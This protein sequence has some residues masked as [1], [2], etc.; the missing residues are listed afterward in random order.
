MSVE[1][2]PIN[3]KNH[4]GYGTI[5]NKLVAAAGSPYTYI[6]LKPDPRY[7]LKENV[8]RLVVY[9][10]K[11]MISELFF[12]TEEGDVWQESHQHN[13]EAQHMLGILCRAPPTFRN[14][15]M[16]N[17]KTVVSDWFQ[18]SKMHKEFLEKISTW[19]KDV[20]YICRFLA[21]ASKFYGSMD[22]MVRYPVCGHLAKFN[23]LKQFQLGFLDKKKNEVRIH[24]MHILDT[25]LSGGHFGYWLVKDEPIPPNLTTDTKIC[26]MEWQ[27]KDPSIKRF[28]GTQQYAF[29]LQECMLAQGFDAWRFKGGKAS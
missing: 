7:T 8:Q 2:R 1:L 3:D 14:Q 24:M 27:D 28:D 11:E 12:K 23:S 18:K 19:S 20:S 10:W 5:I 15:G 6:T 16:D 29:D 17:V 25:M 4:I 9:L 13:A 26:R 22:T 21:R